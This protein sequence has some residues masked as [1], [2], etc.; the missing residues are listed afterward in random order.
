MNAEQTQT[1]QKV[2]IVADPRAL[3]MT[4]IS[5]QQP[6]STQK[7]LYPHVLANVALDLMLSVTEEGVPDSINVKGIKIILNN[8]GTKQVIMPNF[9]SANSRT[10][11]YPVAKLGDKREAY[12]LA[13]Y[14]ALEKLWAEQPQLPEDLPLE[15]EVAAPAE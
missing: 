6:S 5:I 8:V 14:E 4:H 9:Q 1:V 15:I 3:G 13:M 2:K 7:R 11:F 12:L 10:P